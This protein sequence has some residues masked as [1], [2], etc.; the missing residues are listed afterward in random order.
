ME[1][2]YHYDIPKLQAQYELNLNKIAQETETTVAAYFNNLTALLEEAPETQRALTKFAKR[3]GDKDDYRSIERTI[4]HLKNLGTEAYIEDLYAILGAYDNGNWR[5][6]SHI[7]EKTENEYAQFHAQIAAAQKTRRT[8]TTIE[9]TLTLKEY[10]EQLEQL[11]EAKNESKKT[12]LAIDDSP[13]ILKSISSVLNKEY[14][15]HTLVKPEKLEEVLQKITP[16][17]FLLDYQM[18]H[19]NGFELI[20]IIRANSKHETTPIIFL[21]SEGTL[22]RVKGALELGAADF[23]VKPVNADTLREKISKWI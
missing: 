9:T 16:D 17:L 11:S 20:P 2:K 12:I 4:A 14:R 8:E 7:A 6:A 23:I 22:D 13:V 10:I 1:N 19:L 21:T 18:P 15:I 5:L 3:D